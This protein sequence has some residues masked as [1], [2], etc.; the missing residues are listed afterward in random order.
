MST[1]DM[2]FILTKSQNDV[3]TVSY[4]LDVEALTDCTRT[5]A[6]SLEYRVVY[7]ASNTPSKLGFESPLILPRKFFLQFAE[8]VWDLE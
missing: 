1:T 4:C 6:E 3:Q 7:T 2:S 5:L 8:K